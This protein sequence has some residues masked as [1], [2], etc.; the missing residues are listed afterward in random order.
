MLFASSHVLEHHLSFCHLILTDDGDERNGFGVSITHLL[1]HLGGIGVDFGTNT[2][3]TKLGKQRQA[4]VRLSLAKV[5]EEHLGGIDRLLGIEIKLVEHV[6]NAVCSKR[7]AY[8]TETWHAED[9]CE[10]IVSATTRDGAYLHIEGLHFENGT[11]VVV[12]TTS[13]RQVEFNGVV[14]SVKFGKDVFHLLHTL[15]THFG[16]FEHLP[17]GGEFLVIRTAEA[18][19]RLQLVDGF[20]WDAHFGE[21]GIDSIKT[22]LV[23]LINGD[24]DV[25]YLVSLSYEFGNAR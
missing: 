14:Q 18:D 16:V 13:Q 9:T 17:H 5:D 25:H 11:R 24:G 7:D 8:T 10:V 23:Q 15:Q 12:Q 4:E 6:E 1:L 2:G 22:N 20:C 21:F 19:D 3:G